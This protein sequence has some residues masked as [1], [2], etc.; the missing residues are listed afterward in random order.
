MTKPS[1]ISSPSPRV[2]IIIPT[3]NNA[4]F[5]PQALDSVLNQTYT[6]HEIIV[7]D[8]GST[9]ETSVVLEPYLKHIH[10]VYQANTGSASARNFGMQLAK[11]EFV[12]FLD[13]DD[14]FLADKLTDQ[15]DYFDKQPNFGIINSGWHIVN[16]QGKTIVDVEPWLYSP[17]LNLETWLLWKPIFLG[18][19][20]IRRQWLEKVSCMDSRLNQAHDVDLILRLSLAGCKA[21]WLPKITVSYRRHEFNK[22]RN[23]PQ[24]VQSI[25]MV[26]DNFFSKSNIPRKISLMENKVRYYTSVW[27]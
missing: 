5:L 25:H 17:Q 19:M 16:K 11:G 9:D 1:V 21:S 26:L 23:G 7:V 13:A 18:A 3:F 2:S 4:L 20:M 24:Q 6:S 22:T 8:D 12:V 10:Y 27:N 15:V 14:Y